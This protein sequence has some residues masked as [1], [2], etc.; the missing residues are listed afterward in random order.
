MLTNPTKKIMK[1]IGGLP[2][3]NKK[4]AKNVSSGMMAPLNRSMKKAQANSSRNEPVMSVLKMYQ[5][6]RKTRMEAKNGTADS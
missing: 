4:P 3:I 2:E 6:I 5:S 1:A